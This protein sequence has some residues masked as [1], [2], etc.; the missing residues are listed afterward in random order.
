MGGALAG[1][2]GVAG[3]GAL[4]SQLLQ[5]GDRLDKVAIQTGL[6]VEQLQAPS[7]CRVS[8]RSRDR[9]LQFLDE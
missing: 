6:S 8:I 9:D 1:V 7:V 4:S 2:V 5:V 3:L